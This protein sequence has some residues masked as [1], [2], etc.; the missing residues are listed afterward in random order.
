MI[1][2]GI[3]FGTTNSG[4]VKLAPHAQPERYGDEAGGPYPSI[5]AIDR[6]T[7]Q[8]VGGRRV[9]E[10]RDHYVESGNYH[11]IN[12]VKW[13]LGK[14]QAWRTEERLWTPQDVASFILGQLSVRAAS[15]GVDEIRRAAITIPVGFPPDSRADLRQAAERAGIQLSTFV[16]ESTAAFMRY[17]PQLRHCRHVAVFDWGGGTLDISILQLKDGA[18]IE[19]ATE[20]MEIAG[21]ELDVDVARAVHARVMEQRRTPLSFDTMSS[22]DRDTLRTKCEYAK[23]QL[24]HAA[25]ADIL[26]SSYGGAPLHV[27]LTTE[28]FDSIVSPHVDLAIERLTAAVESARL[29]FDAVDRLLLVGGSSKLGLLKDRL[30]RDAR[31]SAALQIA[32]DAEWDVAHGAA[33]VEQAN[34]EYELAE[35]IGIILSDN[36]YYELISPRERHGGKERSI[37][38]SLVEDAR[39]ANI[40]IDKRP[41]RDSQSSERALAFGV[42]T[43]GFNLEELRLRY[44]ITADMM[45]Q[46]EAGSASMPATET[47]AKQYGKLLFAYRF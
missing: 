38:L 8:A 22:V 39:Q 23:R 47:A 27:E 40:I 7:G 17:L 18:I 2:F 20:G 5:V 41:T 32:E 33:I 1:T 13:L 42:N 37:V 14:Q 29:S 36:S 15:L 6:A 16:T 4:V 34:G 9:W 25:S 24:S 3:D 43:L 11:V 44:R 31:Y 21:D 45:L 35:S 46:V 10:H 30:R 26:L 28:W 19:V 12:S